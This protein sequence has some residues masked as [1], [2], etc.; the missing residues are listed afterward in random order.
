MDNI[1]KQTK[2]D[3]DQ[4]AEVDQQIKAIKDRYDQLKATVLTQD[5][6]DQIADIDAEMEADLD[7]PLSRLQD[8]VASIKANTITVGHTIKGQHKKSIFLKGRESW[9]NKALDGFAEAHPEIKKFKRIG[10]PSARISAA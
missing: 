7:A 9:D 10:K 6:L 2:K 4:L 3:L 8:L 5:V 1:I